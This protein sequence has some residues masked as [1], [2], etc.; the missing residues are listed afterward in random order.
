[1]NF[2][3]LQYIVE[4][5]KEQKTDKQIEFSL[6]SNLMLLDQEKLKFLIENNVSVCTSLD[7]DEELHNRNRPYFHKNAFRILEEK[8]EMIRNSQGRV[9]AIQTTTRYTLNKY[10]YFI[11]EVQHYK[12]KKLSKCWHF[13]FDKNIFDDVKVIKNKLYKKRVD[14]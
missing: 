14:R 7:G 5:T 12:T 2:K 8:I 9:S 11:E 3:T 1:M 6:V 4:Y 13:E 10:M